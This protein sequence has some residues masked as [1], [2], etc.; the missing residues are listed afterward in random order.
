MGKMKVLMQNCKYE[1][2]FTY[3]NKCINLYVRLYV[4]ML[5]RFYLK[6]YLCMGV[7]R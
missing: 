5:L 3:I 2:V 6:V 1:Q 4:N 7:G